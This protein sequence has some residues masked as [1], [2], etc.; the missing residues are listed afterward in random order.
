V[1]NGFFLYGVHSS[2]HDPVIN[3]GDQYPFPV[4]PDTADPPLTRVY[5]TIM[6]AGPALNPPVF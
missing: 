2:G 4:F 6:V 5:S 3:Q 1:K